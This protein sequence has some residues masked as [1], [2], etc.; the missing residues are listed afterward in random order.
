ML[1]LFR[2]KTASLKQRGKT[3]QNAR[4]LRSIEQ[5]AILIEI[6]NKNLWFLFEIFGERIYVT[7]TM[8]STWIVSAV[9]IAFAF[10]VRHKVKSFTDKPKGF[11]N[12][13]ETMVE[14]ISNLVRDTMGE[15]LEYFGGYFFSVFTFILV[16][17]YVGILGLRPPT[18]DLSTTVPLALM[19]FFMI[20]YMG[21]TK[22]KGKYFKEYLQPI[23]LFLPLNIIGEF[24]RPVSLAFRLFGNILGGLIILQLMYSMLPF[25]ARFV[26]PIPA[27]GLFDFFAG[28]LQAFVFTILSMTFIKLRSAAD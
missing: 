2:I 5:G 12:A 28:G 10:F 17:N 26:L 19:T 24:A 13:I 7:E 4:S 18:T 8:R 15:K 1:H 6:A 27:H 21:M 3:A 22:Q 14:M 11:Q 9:L 20:H 25:V 16:S 23:F